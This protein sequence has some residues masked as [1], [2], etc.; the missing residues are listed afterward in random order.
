MPETT[1]SIKLAKVNNLAKTPRS[2]PFSIAYVAG[3]ER[4]RGRGN[5]G[6]RE[7]DFITN[8]SIGRGKTFRKG[9]VTS[10]YQAEVSGKTRVI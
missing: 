9:S 5:L 7:M 2:S 10:G 4:G 8:I 3:V 6:A 1:F